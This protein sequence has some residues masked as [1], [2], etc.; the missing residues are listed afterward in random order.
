MMDPPLR[1]DAL[2]WSGAVLVAIG[3]AYMGLNLPCGRNLRWNQKRF[4]LFCLLPLFLASVFMTI[5][6]AWFNYYGRSLIAWPVFGFGQPQT[7]VPFLYLGIALHILSWLTS[8]LPAHGFRTLEFLFRI[9]IGKK[10]HSP[11]STRVT[12]SKCAIFGGRKN[13]TANSCPS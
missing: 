1:S 9:R 8:L 13:F 10:I 6:W 5:Y 11:G 4:L 3:V 2:F 7:W 12:T